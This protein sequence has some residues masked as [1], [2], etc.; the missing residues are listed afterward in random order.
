VVSPERNQESVF[1]Q[2]LREIKDW[3]LDP[4][5]TVVVM[6]QATYHTGNNSIKYLTDLGIGVIF[7]PASS[8]NL[9]PIG[10]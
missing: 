9:N 7:L 8:S 5:R 10:K 1:R 3:P 4:L 6:D 2:L